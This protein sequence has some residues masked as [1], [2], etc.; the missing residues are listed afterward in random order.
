MKPAELSAHEVK[1]Y[2][3]ESVSRADALARAHDALACALPA[4]LEAAT[5]IGYAEGYIRGLSQSDVELGTASS[6]PEIGQ[7]ATAVRDGQ[8]SITEAAFQL[9]EID[10]GLLLAS[11]QF[12]Q[13]EHAPNIVQR[14]L[15]YL[16]K[17]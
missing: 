8:V 3:L 14:V 17:L 13:T 5:R 1:R 2:L 9:T 12:A 7:A 15:N 10:R 6:V 11:A 4:M 16:R